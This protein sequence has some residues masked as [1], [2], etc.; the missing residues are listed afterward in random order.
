[1]LSKKLVQMSRYAALPILLIVVG[2]L[3]LA[4]KDTAFGRAVPGFHGFIILFAIITVER[5][6]A[7]RYAVSQQ[8]MVWRDLMSTSVQLLLLGSLTGAVV[9][10]VLHF[11]PQTFLG[12][13]FLFGLSGQL[14]PLWLQ[15]LA[16]FL[17]GN[18]WQYWM[19]RFQHHNEFLWTL[20][21]YHH[22]VTHI[23]ATNDFVS[24][25]L[26]F[27]LR[28]LLGGLVLGIVGFNPVAIVLAGAFNSYG[29]FSHCGADVRGGWLN[30]FFNT[31]E[32]HRW[33]HSV[34]LPDD[35]RFR[36]GCNFGVGVSFLDILFGTFYLPKDAKG[37]VVPPPRLGHPSGYADEPNYLKMFLGVRAFPSLARLFREK[38]SPSPAE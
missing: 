5:I 29:Q 14:G 15:V 9:L 16:V 11:F 17:L 10:P 37:D 31:P 30:Y 19:H 25:P 38:H 18:L 13:R 12:R 36:Y 20:H 34:E 2:A 7:Y 28:N 21:G 8:H 4:V 6:Y 1:M 22:S 24:N 35:K 32:V 23:Q 26:D 33:H 3:T 27:I